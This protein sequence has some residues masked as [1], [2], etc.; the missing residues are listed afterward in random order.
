[1]RT[2]NILSLLLAI[3]L[4]VGLLPTTV[5][6]AGDTD[7]AIQLGASG[8][9]GYNNGYDYIYMGS[10]N[11][12]PVKWRVLDTKTNMENANEGDGLF[13]LSEALLGSGNYG[14]VYFQQNVHNDGSTY[15]KG[16]SH[17]DGITEAL[18]N[19][20]QGSDA[21]VWCNIFESSNL[22]SRELAAILSTTKSDEAFTSSTPSIPF[23]ASTN[24]LNGDQVFFLSAQEA[25]N[26]DYGFTDDTAR[27]ANY[28]AS[29]GGW[30]LRSPSAIITTNAGVVYDVGCVDLYGVLGGWAARP[31]FNLNLNSVLFTSAADG[32]KSDTDGDS[33]LTAVGTA[34]S[35]WKLTL[36]DNSRSTLTAS[37]SKTA[38]Y[39]GEA[40]TI[41]Y[42]NAQ[43]GSNEY[44]SAMIAQGD[45]ILY[46][47]RIANNSASGQANLT[48]PADLAAGSYTLKVFSEQYNGDKKTDYASAF[49]DI[50][51]T[52]TEPPFV[53]VTDI[54]MTNTTVQ[55]DTDLALT[56]TVTPTD[57]TNQTITWTVV[58]AGT[59]GANISGTNTFHATAAGTAKIKATITNGTA[60]GTDYTKE[61]EITVTA[62][63][64]PPTIT[65]TSLADGTVGTT[66]SQTL[67][68][69]G[70]ATIAWSIK[71]GTLPAG[72]TL[73]S[74]TGEISGTPTAEGTSTFTV[75]ASNGISPNAEKELSIKVNPV[76][77]TP[78]YT[79]S[80]NPTT[81]NFGSATEGYTTAPAAQTITI[82]NTGNH[83]ITLT[84]PTATHY[85]IGTLS[86]I[87]L[88]PNDTAT[89]TVQPN[90]G[91]AAGT[92]DETITVKGT[93][94]GNSTNT[95]NITANFEVTSGGQQPTPTYTIS[96]SVSPAN[97]GSVSGGGTY[98][99]N[100]TVS[101]TATAATGYH[102]LK[103][104]ENGADVAGAGATYTFTATADRTLVAVFEA[105]GGTTPHTHTFES[106]WT[107]DSTGHWHKATCE[108]DVK[109]GFAA[110]TSGGAA[111]ETTP[112]TC[113]ECGY[114]IAPVLQH[115]HTFE[116]GWTS[117]SSGH[118][119]KA[120]CEHTGEK[121]SFA[122]HTPGAAATA[123]TPQTCSV[124]G[125]VITPATGG[126]GDGDDSPSYS[127]YTITATAGDGGTISPSGRRSVREGLD[128][129]Y[130]ITPASG[131]VISDVL[132]D[133]RSVGAVS[134]YTFDNVQRAH[135]IE[136]QF[137]EESKTNPNTGGDNPGT[138]P[139]N[140][141]TGKPPQSPATGEGNP[142][143]DVK[144]TDW[145]Y[146]DVLFVYYEG[147]MLGTSDT[148]F[149]PN[150]T[151]TRGMMAAILWR[152]EGSPTPSG[153]NPFTDVPADEYYTDA[154]TWTKEQGIFEGYGNN[155]FGPNDP[156]TRQ[157]LAAIFYR[158][159]AFKGYDLTP[160]DSLDR[161]TDT[162]EIA[163]WAQD[164]VKWAVGSGLMYGTTD[165]TFAPKAT[166]TRAQIAAMLHRFIE[167][168][169]LEERETYTGFMGWVDPNSDYLN[170][171]KTGDSSN[172]G[173]WAGLTLFAAAGTGATILAY[174][175]KRRKDKD[176][177][178]PTP[179]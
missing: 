152:M 157:Q 115:T 150:G 142:F 12:S 56:A 14:D 80:A 84:Q 166:A 94:G 22:D 78:V 32:G 38:V 117:D 2:K 68:A 26:A 111:T 101:L 175:R 54:Q 49:V 34:G 58:D 127:Y 97:S 11:S 172:A 74:A 79:I 116:S 45:T 41:T 107:S 16:S 164:A 27:V 179:A 174:W 90:G 23:A 155:L 126:T 130:T 154:T 30:W 140:P 89:F 19:A 42:S 13:L 138:T 96:A 47:G 15:H 123:T 83:Q 69:T 128:K 8:I 147:I 122:A 91:L 25:K 98:S 93:N 86:K 151:L 132:V 62:A 168:Y 7:K 177:A 21:Q 44:V 105:D 143:T 57:A 158:Y 65:T 63:P 114:E 106:G 28:G 159:A 20:W 163:D 102:F 77:V 120:T 118:W 141:D 18:A 124:C 110:H 82:T 133:G 6:A 35:E 173:H 5:F 40:I 104:T 52:V 81:L 55:E 64:V 139:E 43:T 129:T 72:L 71:T 169:E 108:H 156:I 67:T 148:T 51:L 162:A 131:Y 160:T 171:P 134:S 9:E 119:H 73:N 125:Y 50:T 88:T 121:G 61:F 39:T 145:F 10:Y 176:G 85:T 103:W 92:Y 165:T 170:F 66:Y 153:E 161:F 53:A 95:V 113:T 36:K 29:A 3:C 33:N 109:D 76:P 146:E 60:M 48:I 99:E 70:D 17:Q 4:V 1:M 100:A 87:D 75:V 59:T 144:E 167:K 37:A 46:Y 136:A 112:E 137:I 149:S 31:A 135:T 178:T 24:I